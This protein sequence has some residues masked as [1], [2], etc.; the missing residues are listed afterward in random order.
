MMT[1]YKI[2]ENPTLYCLIWVCMFIKYASIAMPYMFMQICEI[3]I[4]NR[5]S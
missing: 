4:C 3:Y 2:Y 5:S 1:T